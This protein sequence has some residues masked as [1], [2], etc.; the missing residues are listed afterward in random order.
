MG[1]FFR[2]LEI[3]GVSPGK[4]NGKLAWRADEVVSAVGYENV[5]ETI[6]DCIEHE[7]FTEGLEYEIIKNSTKRSDN[8][9][10]FKPTEYIFYEQGLYGFILYG[11]TPTSKELR[12]KMIASTGHNMG[13]LFEMFLN[14]EH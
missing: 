12:S 1:E 6:K 2:G 7:E 14:S 11:K 5:T 13:E 8:I 10:E 9:I 3:L 4:L